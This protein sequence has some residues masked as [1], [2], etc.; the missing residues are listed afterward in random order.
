MVTEAHVEQRSAARS[1]AV[2]LAGTL[3]I[4]STYGMA[5]FG[6]GL[7]APRLVAERPALAPVVGWA[8]A[9]QFVSYSVAA[10]VAARVSDRRPGAAVLVAGTT[11]ALGCIGVATTASPGWFVALVFLG[12][13]GAG[14]ASPALV[15]LVDAVT[16]P[17]AAATAQSLVNTGTAVGV[18]VAGALAFAV[19][20]T[21]GAWW[22]MAALNALAA[23]GVLLLVRGRAGLGEPAAAASETS[24]DWHPLATPAAAAVVVGAGSALLWSYGPLIATGPGPVDDGSVGF[25]WIALGLGGLLGP[26]TGRLVERRGLARAWA[27]S[28]GAVAVASVALAGAV[29]LGLAWPAY[30][31]MACFGAGYMCLSGVLILWARDAWPEAAGRGTSVLFVAL[32]V[33]QAV[34]AVGFDLWLDVAGAV[35]ACLTAALLCLAGA[36][37]VR[38]R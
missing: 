2:A 25:L 34:G 8:A 15:R 27:W 4:A 12:G 11:A 21:A 26:L 23:A 36:S 20:S 38:R 35:T 32:A 29:G 6:V 17:H 30:V 37:S 7:F 22:T 10:S 9:A 16:P 19:P 5:R 28:V 3:L 13:T 18:V 33:G 14:L 31:A 1:V 24:Y